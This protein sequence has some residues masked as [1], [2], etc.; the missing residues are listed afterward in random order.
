MS[1]LLLTLLSVLHC[2]PETSRPSFEPVANVVAS[3]VMRVGGV[4][5]VARKSRSKSL[6]RYPAGRVFLLP[7][8]LKSPF[9][10][11]QSVAPARLPE[12]V[13]AVVTGFGGEPTRSWS[14][15]DR[16]VDGTLP[17]SWKPSSWTASAPPVR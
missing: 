6:A 11:A 5:V 7:S 15:N 16:S 9:V 17:S 8:L 2:Q 13:P 4:V 14:T 1:I 12:R 3:D 10:P